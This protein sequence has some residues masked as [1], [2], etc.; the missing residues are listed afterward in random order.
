MEPR[1]PRVLIP[2][3][4]A[5]SVEQAGS[6]ARSLAELARSGIPVPE[7]F[8]LPP[9]A[10]T[11]PGPGILRTLG[12]CV[13]VRSSATAEDLADA[14]FAGQFKSFLHVRTPEA[15]ARAI[16]ECRDSVRSEAVRAYCQARGLAPSS[17][18]MA[19]I[20]Q[21]M[22]KAEVAGVLFTV[23][24]VRG[25][26]DEMLIEACA[27]IADELLSGRARGIQIPVRQGRPAASSDLLSPAQVQQLIDIGRAVQR[28]KGAPQDIEWAIEG[29]RL[30]VLQARPITRLYFAG[31]DGQWT[32]A[33]FRDGGVSSEVVTPLVWSLYEFVLQRALPGYLRELRLLDHDFEAGRLFY[34]RPYWNLGAV[35]RCVRALPG[36]VEREFDRDLAVEPTYAGD[37]TR[38]PTNVRTLLRSLPTLLAAGGVLRRQ[39]VRDRQLLGRDL[40]SR[41]SLDLAGVGDGDLLRRFAELVETAYE[42]VEENYFRTIFCTS[43]AK[44][45]LKTFLDGK[46]VSYAALVGGLDEL[47]HFECAQTLWDLANREAGSLESFLARYG[48]HSR[49]ELDLRVPRWSED[50]AFVRDMSQRLIG[51]ESPAEMN[52][53]QRERFAGELERARRLFGPWRRR[54]FA[55][56]LDRLRTCLWLREQMRDLST[57]MYAL[58]RRFVLEIGRR[59]AAAGCLEAPEDIFYLTF[60]EVY[61]TLR[62]P[63]QERVSQRREYEATYLNFRAPNEVGRGFRLAPVEHAGR[64]LT[65][66]GCSAGVASG[67]VAVVADL[68][69]SAK[70]ERGDVLVCPFTDPGWTP[71]LNLAAAVVT[72]SGGLLSHAAVLCREYGIPAAL[73]VTGATR[74]LRDGQLVRVNGETGHVDIL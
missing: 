53:R 20:V 14:S 72:E 64:R 9:T 61:D 58:I 55:R 32:N 12:G 45:A 22:V 36:F 52:R 35:K 65:G 3:S 16:Q 26:E 48:H 40:W 10:R 68:R 59:A 8:V 49:R 46:P 37:G 57:R 63:M 4:R 39:E 13:A 44:Q 1:D 74:L 73:N 27:G 54:G 33:D 18:R 66:I 47:G 7:T 2:L 6:K 23:H 67:R 62:V 50:P 5:T 43:I 38:T 17:I 25:N 42:A 31:I 34:G 19:V 28:L 51:A 11:T 69:D 24:P 29:G 60:R 56:S 30:Y 71:L 41:F 15:L 70:L 21:R